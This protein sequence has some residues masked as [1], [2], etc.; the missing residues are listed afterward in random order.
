MDPNDPNPRKLTV[1][2]HDICVLCGIMR[3]D[4]GDSNHKFS[5]NGELIPVK[6]G[7]APQNQPPKVKP[8][9]MTDQEK[10]DVATAELAKSMELNAVLRLTEVLIEK[11]V[12]TAQDTLYIFS[13]FKG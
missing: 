12:L 5:I 11:C 3:M 4:H 9:H 1:Q 8:E 13:G 10:L 2:P 7:P 6:E